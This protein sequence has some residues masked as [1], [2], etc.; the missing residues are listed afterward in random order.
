MRNRRR[1]L[2]KAAD[3]EITPEQ[4]KQRSTLFAALDDTDIRATL[5]LAHT[6]AHPAKHVVFREGEEGD[7]LLLLLE[8]RVKVSLSSPEGKE[9]ILSILE[10]GQLIGEMSLLD[11]GQR[12]ATVTTMDPCRFLA[13]WRK[14][15]L[16][17]LERRPHVALAL[18][19]PAGSC[20]VEVK[21]VTAAVAGGVG[22]FPDAVSERA[23][24]HM[25]E[26][27]Q[28]VAD[29]ARA[30]VVFC[31][32]RGDVA[33]VRP[34]DLIDPAFATAL[35]RAAAGGV[36]LYALGATL[37]GAGIRLERPLSVDLEWP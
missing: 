22:Y 5:E 28:A 33:V 1:V 3:M 16:G 2:D 27:E 12:S 25:R 23:A 6:E 10:P 20:Y 19:F 9:V 7:R 29:G 32:Q 14:D 21:S 17:F 31:V 18:L 26:L 37:S 24:R 13:I 11:G 8:G 34:A 30:A 36:E 15:F 35:R 4:L